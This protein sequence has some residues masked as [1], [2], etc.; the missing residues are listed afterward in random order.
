MNFEANALEQLLIELVKLY[1]PISGTMQVVMGLLNIVTQVVL[2]YIFTG[3][4][5]R[6]LLLLIYY[7]Y[8]SISFTSFLATGSAADPS[9]TECQ[10]TDGNGYL[11]VFILM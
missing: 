2:I 3:L 5:V 4:L 6:L 7:F 8:S 1:L 9:I 10:Y 11:F